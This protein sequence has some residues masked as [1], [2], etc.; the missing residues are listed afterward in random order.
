M[1]EE[2]IKIVTDQIVEI[3]KFSVDKIEVDLSM[4]RITGMII[5]EEILEVTWENIKILEGRIIE[6]FIVLCKAVH[7]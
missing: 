1:I 3:E 7:I 4:N 5:G 2:I 6:E